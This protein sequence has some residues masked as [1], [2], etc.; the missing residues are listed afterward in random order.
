MTKTRVFAIF[1]VNQFGIYNQS[2]NFWM[3]SATLNV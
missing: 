2:L 1:G 3:Y